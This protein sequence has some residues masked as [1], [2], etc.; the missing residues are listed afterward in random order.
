MIRVTVSYPAKEGARFDHDYYR[1][2][3]RQ[4]ILDKLGH[5]GLVLFLGPGAGHF[6]VVIAEN[7]ILHRAHLPRLLSPR[8][9]EPSLIPTRGQQYFGPIPTRRVCHRRT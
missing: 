4:L 7:R 8:T 3:H 6:F 1:T 9:F 5:H 2:K